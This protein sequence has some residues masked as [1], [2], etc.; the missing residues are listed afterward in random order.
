MKTIWPDAYLG[1]ICDVQIGKTPKRAESRYW[2]EEHPWLSISDMNQ[3]RSLRDTKERITQH[4]VDELNCRAVD[5]GTLLLSFKLSI[6][7]VGIAK[8]RMFTNEAIAHLPIVDSRVERD[9]LYW[10]LRTVPLSAEADR[11]AMGATLN[12]A[13][14]KKIPIPLPPIEEQR[15]IAAILD[16]ADA[17]RAKRRQALAKLDTLTQAIFIDMFGDPVTNPKGLPSQKLG[18]LVKLKSGNGLPAK[19]MIPGPHRVYGGNGVSGFHDQWMFEEPKIV[20]GRVGV[21]CGCV[22][23]T[24]PESWITDNALYV[25]RCN[26]SLDQTC[27]LYTSPSP[28]DS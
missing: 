16:A 24:E 7:K 5:P 23:L 21:Y 22:H 25:E 4:A 28:R 26:V 3:G 9:Y 19:A 17:L 2:G 27:L 12:K 8:R 14:L 20:I 6:G 15:R 11:A 13:K 10:A 1:E 18:D